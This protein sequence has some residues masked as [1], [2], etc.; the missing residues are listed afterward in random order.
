MANQIERNLKPVFRAINMHTKAER[1]LGLFC[2]ERKSADSFSL[3][4][5]RIA[6]CT[7]RTSSSLSV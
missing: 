3:S 1:L 4:V 7:A 2:Y 6:L 5:A